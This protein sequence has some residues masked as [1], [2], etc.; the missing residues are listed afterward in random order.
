MSCQRAISA[1]SR[2]PRK[3]ESLLQRRDPSLRAVL[4][5]GLSGA[6]EQFGVARSLIGIR[7]A[8]LELR[9]PGYKPSSAES[10]ERSSRYRGEMQ[11]SRR[12]LQLRNAASGARCSGVQLR[13]LSTSFPLY[14]G[15][16]PRAWLP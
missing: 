11:R 1:E 16:S 8:P 5:D 4:I 3:A 12:N 2:K 14:A 6:R 15:D 13:K 7:S 10:D 9:A